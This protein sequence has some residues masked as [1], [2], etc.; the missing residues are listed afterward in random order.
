MAYDATF[1][2]LTVHRNCTTC[3]S[4][5]LSRAP[6]ERLAEWRV[7][8]IE[9]IMYPRRKVKFLCLTHAVAFAHKHGGG[10]ID[11]GIFCKKAAAA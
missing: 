3:G 6:V 11:L 5:G 7:T 2:Y 9:G 1:S 10:K 8:F 4:A